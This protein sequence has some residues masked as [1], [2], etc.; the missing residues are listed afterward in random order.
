[1]VC[2]NLL[3]SSSE[4]VAVKVHAMQAIANVVK[5]NEELKKEFLETIELLLPMQSA[6]FMA[7][8][9]MIVKE[10]KMNLAERKS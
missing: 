2:Y 9:K 7:R 4:P 5:R 6:A 3:N 1:M 8:A 10:L